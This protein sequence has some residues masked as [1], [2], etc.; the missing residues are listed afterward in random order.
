MG[1]TPQD[2]AEAYHPTY[3]PAADARSECLGRLVFE[4]SRQ[5]ELAWG[6]PKGRSN[7][8]ILGFSRLLRGARDGI[9]MGNVAVVVI[10]VANQK[11][12]L[13]MQESAAMD[14]R[15]GLR[16][17]DEN[18]RVKKLVAE[19][20]AEQLEFPE[21]KAD[22]KATENFKEGIRESI[23]QARQY[24][25]RKQ[26]LDKD[27]HPTDWGLPDS[28]GYIAGPTLYAFLLRG[29]YAFQFMSTGGEGEAPFEQ[30]VVA[31]KDLLSRFEPRSLY[32]VPN[33][34]GVCIPHGFIAD[35]G[36][37]PFNADVSFRYADSPGVIYTLST[38][39][40]GERNYDPDDP[41]IEATARATVVGVMGNGYGRKLKVLGPKSTQI[42]ARSGLMG[43][44]S[45]DEGVSGYSVYAGVSGVPGSRVL[46]HISLNMRSF[47]RQTAPDDV[48]VD[49]P[50]FEQSLQR[51]EQTLHSTRTRRVDGG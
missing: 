14:K 46:P 42:G 30:R 39:V 10:A 15:R 25:I 3:V 23:E 48:K 33:K 40:V 1:P 11:T 13:D 4:V 17:F 20:L 36:K 16:S 26:N 35:D 49:P 41:L 34:A 29:G 12:I 28:T 31:F 50:P 2:I 8:E 19:D 5:S 45:T 47:D 37:G 51:F 44:V 38:G 24:A 7:E 6:L 32:Q 43:A 18:I 9:Q 22:A 21:I 27:W